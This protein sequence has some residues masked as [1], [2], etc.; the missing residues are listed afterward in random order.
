[1]KHSHKIGVWHILVAYICGGCLCL[2]LIGYKSYNWWQTRSSRSGIIQAEREVAELSALGFEPHDEALRMLQS[3]IDRLRSCVT[4]HK[5]R[6]TIDNGYSVCGEQLQA[7]IEMHKN[8]LTSYRRDVRDFDRLGV[9]NE[10]ALAMF[11]RTRASSLEE[12]LA[13]LETAHAQKTSIPNDTVSSR[14]QAMR[15]EASNLVTQY[16]EELRVCRQKGLDC[17]H[18]RVI[19]AQNQIRRNM[20]FADD[21]AHLMG[22][23]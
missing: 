23:E 22:Q 7:L 14:L 3:K 9:P 4:A 15:D 13:I 2:M 12:Q 16:K 11:V 18:H 5:S 19:H 6:S 10:S 8:M 17:G 21:L 20:R 1:M